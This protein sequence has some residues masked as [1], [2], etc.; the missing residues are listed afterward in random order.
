MRWTYNSQYISTICS[1]YNIGRGLY[2]I[3]YGSS[4]RLVKIW[5]GLD[6]GL[7]WFLKGAELRTKRSSFSS[8]KRNRSWIL[9]K[10]LLLQGWPNF[11][12]GGPYAMRWKFAGAGCRVFW[13]RFFLEK[14]FFGMTFFR[15]ENFSFY[16]TSFT[17]SHSSSFFQQNTNGQMA[18]RMPRAAFAS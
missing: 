10:E 15:K 4:H 9:T 1:I 2:S 13:W 5:P 7:A 14:K 16:T 17:L 8:R 3:H 12:S 6:F 11:L 18:W